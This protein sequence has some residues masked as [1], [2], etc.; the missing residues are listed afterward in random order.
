M[1][2]YK[3]QVFIINYKMKSR[4]KQRYFVDSLDWHW[5]LYWLGLP[6]TDQKL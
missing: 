1:G 2:V 5:T 4:K 3:K 6:A